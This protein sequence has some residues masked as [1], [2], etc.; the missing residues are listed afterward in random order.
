M[1]CDFF[2]FNEK[3]FNVTPDTRYLYLSPLHQG[4]LETLRYGIQER[5]GFLLLTGEVG[6]GK[7]LSLRALASLTWNGRK[8]VPNYYCE[9]PRPLVI[10]Q[11]NQNKQPFFMNN[12]DRQFMSLPGNR[13]SR[14][15][16]KNL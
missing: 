6:T 14:C 5:K 13:V 8:P 9:S 7:T 15:F 4:V 10:W 16:L 3:P 2:G 12:L 11:L 1:Y